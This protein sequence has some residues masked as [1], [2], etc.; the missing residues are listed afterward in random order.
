M[1]C[2]LNKPVRF[3]SIGKFDTVAKHAK[4][5]I[6]EED[7]P[8]LLKIISNQFAG[9]DFTTNN[10]IHPA[11]NSRISPRNQPLT[12]E[13]TSDLFGSAIVSPRIGPKTQTWVPHTP[14]QTD[15]LSIRPDEIVS[16]NYEIVN[17]KK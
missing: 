1:K 15:S 7:V 11:V 4:P 5:S 8:P 17:G 6:A 2:Y 13:K 12:S 9:S 16:V 3:H 14:R 10:K